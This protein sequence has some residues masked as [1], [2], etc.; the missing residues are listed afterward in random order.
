MSVTG[1]SFKIDSVL[2]ES[3]PNI[4]AATSY[5]PIPP[6]SEVCVELDGCILD[7]LLLI[8]PMPCLFGKKGIIGARTLVDSW[9][10]LVCIRLA[11]VSNRT[12]VI[13]RKMKRDK[14][15]P[16]SEHMLVEDWQQQN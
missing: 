3:E 14:V 4:F 9:N 7:E 12:M 16:V 5:I 2:T 11:N 15:F 8:E 13:P 10:N 6:S 1:S